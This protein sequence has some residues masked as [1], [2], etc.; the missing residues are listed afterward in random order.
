[1]L[2]LC[3]MVKQEGDDQIIHSKQFKQ[4]VFLPKIQL[5]TIL[6]DSLYLLINYLSA[7]FRLVLKYLHKPIDRIPKFI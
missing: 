7:F 2:W 5:L 3:D 4:S 1:M 6:S